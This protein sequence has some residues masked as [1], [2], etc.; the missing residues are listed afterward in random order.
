[1]KTRLYSRQGVQKE[2]QVWNAEEKEILDVQSEGTQG[3]FGRTQREGR[4]NISLNLRENNQ[5]VKI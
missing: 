4:R 2:E 3:R 5:R 1:M